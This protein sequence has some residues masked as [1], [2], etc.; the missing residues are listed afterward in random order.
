MNLLHLLY[1]GDC[2]VSLRQ[3]KWLARQEA[4]VP[5]RLLPHRAE[6]N[7]SN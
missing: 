7:S 3:G 2:L 6:E 4:I 5:L 1:D